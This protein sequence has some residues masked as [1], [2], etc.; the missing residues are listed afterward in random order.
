MMR[1][2]SGFSLLETLIAVIV[3]TALAGTFASM[4][5]LQNKQ[6]AKTDYREIE[7]RE[8]S[9]IYYAVKA[10]MKENASAVTA[11]SQQLGL[12]T[13][14]TAG[15]LPAGF[16]TRGGV[17]GRTPWRQDYVIYMR[18]D[19]SDSKPRA[20][21][22]EGTASPDSANLARA[23][24]P[25]TPTSVTALKADIATKVTSTYKIPAATIA[26]GSTTAVGSLNAFSKNLAGLLPAAVA[27]NAAAVLIGFPD[28]EPPDVIATTH[29]R[30]GNCTFA[31][32]TTSTVFAT[33]GQPIAAQCPAGTQ[34][35][36]HVAV[37]GSTFEGFP[38]CRM[39]H[40]WSEPNYTIYPTDI[41]D[42]TIS[43]VTDSQPVSILM[44]LPW[45]LLSPSLGTT[46]ITTLSG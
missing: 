43:P 3:L 14:I 45:K 35:L 22:Q 18:L 16:A 23:G 7:T 30:W 38:Y 2:E 32:P 6:E 44:S 37:G 20:V 15:K 12:N 11:T 27:Q 29:S 36:V 1:K 42:L 40:H 28:L 5:L 8:L 10:Y 17:L 33:Y 26:A 31:Q 46:P 13:L 19:P 4:L 41:G 34:N 25:N 24:I 21:V 9:Q 39:N